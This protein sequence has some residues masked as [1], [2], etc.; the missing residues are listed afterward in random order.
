MPWL[1]AWLGKGFAALVAVF[2][3]G[4]G[5]K[6]AT[7]VAAGVFFVGITVALYA[8]INGI[9]ATVGA[10][11]IPDSPALEWFVPH[12]IDEVIAAMGSTRVVA[13]VYAVRREYYQLKMF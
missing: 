5:R 8:G 11:V 9:V 1:I 10:V 13:M 7:I 6:T 3:E 4:I 2:A 12:N